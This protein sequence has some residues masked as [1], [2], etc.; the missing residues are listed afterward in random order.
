MRY[1]FVVIA[2]A[3]LMIAASCTTTQKLYAQQD[4]EVYT[5]SDNNFTDNNQDEPLINPGADVTFEQFYTDLS[6]YGRWIDYPQYGRVWIYNEPGFQPYYSGGHWAYTQFGWTWVSNYRWGWAPFHYGRWSYDN[7]IGWFWI[8]G[9]QWGPAWVSWRRGADFYGWAPLGPG[10][11]ININIGIPADR[12]I[13]VPHRY[14]GYSN[15]NRYRVNPR[16]NVTIIHNTTIINNTRVYNNRRY[17]T[18]PNRVEV[19]RYSGRAV[20]PVDVR[21]VERVNVSNRNNNTHVYRPDRNGLNN[22]NN[23][24]RNNNLNREP[25]RRP[26]QNINDLPSRNNNNRPNRFKPVEVNPNTST[27]SNTP[28]ATNNGSNAQVN[29]NSNQLNN[30]N[31]NRNR[32]W[33]K[34]NQMMQQQ[35]ATQNKP[36]RSYSPQGD[37]SAAPRINNRRLERQPQNVTPRQNS[38]QNREYN[39]SNRPQTQHN[40]QQKRNGRNN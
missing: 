37:N 3:A 7:G 2:A 39:N 31:A 28:P 38:F 34:R 32:E 10:V 14:I 33:L 21:S 4:D 9:Y 18:G 36:S 30:G 16:Q 29:P 20:R 19:E 26:A 40:A 8:P 22:G 25:A 24:N 15:F 13:F 6:P 27:N 17:V 23:N 11:G 12:W 5:D 1:R 35:K